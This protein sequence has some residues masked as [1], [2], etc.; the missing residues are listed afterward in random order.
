MIQ[1]L[2]IKDKNDVYDFFSRV[3]DKHEDMYITINNER[4]FFK[5][6]WSLIEKTL[7]TQEVYGLY[8]NGLK[9]IMIIVKNKGFRPYVKLLAENSKYTI[10]MLKFLKWNFLGQT[11]FFKLKKSNPL[12]NMIQKTGFYKIGDRGLECLFEKKAIKEIH[13]TTAKDDYLPQ[14]EG[15]LY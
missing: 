1:N 3:H 7:S 15:R 8:N 13:K 5:N 2:K 10:D 11:L 4:K 6:N 14:E 12:S 9:A